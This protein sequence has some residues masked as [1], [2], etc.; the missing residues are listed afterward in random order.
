MQTHSSLSFIFG[1]LFSEP[2]EA[3][4]GTGEATYLF[5]AVCWGLAANT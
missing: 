5:A 2:S 4:S 1:L 3:M